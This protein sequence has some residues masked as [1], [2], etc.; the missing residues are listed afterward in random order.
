MISL[1]V[2][3]NLNFLLQAGSHISEKSRSRITLPKIDRLKK[4]WKLWNKMALLLRKSR[5]HLHYISYSSSL[6]AEKRQIIKEKLKELG[7]VKHLPSSTARWMANKAK[8]R[9]DEEKDT[10]F[11]FGS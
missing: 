6:T 1:P 7:W 10:I 11:Q 4:P 3:L 9:E 5:G 8:R 2:V